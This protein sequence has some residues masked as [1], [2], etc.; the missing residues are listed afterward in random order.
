M[1]AIGVPRSKSLLSLVLSRMVSLL[2]S[3]SSPSMFLSSAFLHHHLS[4]PPQLRLMSLDEVLPTAKPGIAEW[5]EA[6]NKVWDNLS[7]FA[8]LRGRRVDASSFILKSRKSDSKRRSNCSVSHLAS[9]TTHS[10]ETRPSLMAIVPSLITSLVGAG[11]TPSRAGPF[12]GVVGCFMGKEDPILSEYKARR[13]RLL[14][15]GPKQRGESQ[16]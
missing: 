1:L 13:P 15:V 16:V 7:L 2:D 14:G 4:A 12:I 6:M 11:W 8:N 5:N 3:F 9:C 10:D